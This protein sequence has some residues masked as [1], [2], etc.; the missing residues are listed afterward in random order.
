M[1]SSHTYC[2]LTCQ[3]TG[4]QARRK[5]LRAYH[6]QQ[7]ALSSGNR[8][9]CC[10]RSTSRAVVDLFESDAIR[11]LHVKLRA[12]GTAPHIL[13]LFRLELCSHPLLPTGDTVNASDEILQSLRIF[14]MRSLIS[15]FFQSCR[16]TYFVKFSVGNI[17][18]RL[19]SNGVGVSVTARLCYIASTRSVPLS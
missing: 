4:W 13:S 18:M 9:I 12:C 1:K 10:V 2:R 8:V 7:Y 17:A 14:R 11:E 16:G 6:L 3:F 19:P 5:V 15:L